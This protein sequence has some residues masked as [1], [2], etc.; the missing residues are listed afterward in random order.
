MK[1][2][3]LSGLIIVFFFLSFF[4]FGSS[5]VYAQCDDDNLTIL[6]SMGFLGWDGVTI[7]ETVALEAS[8]DSLDECAHGEGNLTGKITLPEYIECSSY[9]VGQL[10][11]IFNASDRNKDAFMTKYEYVENR[12]LTDEC[13]RIFCAMNVKV[14]PNVFGCLPCVPYWPPKTP[15]PPPYP[16]APFWCC[17]CPPGAP[18]PAEEKPQNALSSV[19]FANGT[20]F[21]E[22]TEH[23]YNMFDRNEVHGIWQL[24]W[25][26]V[27][28]H[29]SREDATLNIEKAKVSWND[30]DIDVEG[31]FIPFEEQSWTD[32]P[33]GIL[34]VILAGEKVV[35]QRVELEII[36]NNLVYEDEGNLNGNISV[37][38]VENSEDTTYVELKIALDPEMFPGGASSSPDKVECVVRVGDDSDLATGSDLIG[39]D[40]AWTELGDANWSYEAE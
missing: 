2:T 40:K 33:F 25:L 6:E 26:R 12:I 16:G 28:G 13:K 14:P 1:K 34:I 18:C 11:G 8:F 20:D 38:K 7:T 35:E 32:N 29:W 31:E 15:C 24:E 3:K 37:F 27:W 19:E 5:N 17:P 9:G 4:L 22:C 21:G 23:V 36:G 10:S 30:S 39:L